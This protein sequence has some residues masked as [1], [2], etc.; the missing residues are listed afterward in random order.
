[1]A[2]VDQNVEVTCSSAATQG[3]EAFWI[4]NGSVYGL[5]QVPSGFILCGES[6]CDPNTL[7]IPV[8]RSEMNGFTF[9]CVIIDYLNNTQYL[10]D[11]VVLEVVAFDGQLNRN[12]MTMCCCV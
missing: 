12:G 11:I 7:T 2:G 9:Q 3:S 4:I 1:M 5:L 8:L 10:E 6:I